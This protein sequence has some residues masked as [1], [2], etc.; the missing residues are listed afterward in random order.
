MQGLLSRHRTAVRLVIATDGASGLRL[1]RMERPD[2]IFVDLQLPD[3]DG[4]DLL[5]VLHRLE[6]VEVAPLVAVSA[7]AGRDAI[8]RAVAA[9]AS[10]FVPKPIDLERVLTLVDTFIRPP[11]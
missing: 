5:A 8:S 4:I 1:A 2:V 11:R 3:A 10:S 7:H 9:G 6:G